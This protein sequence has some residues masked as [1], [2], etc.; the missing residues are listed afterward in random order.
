MGGRNR[1]GGGGTDGRPPPLICE[2][3]LSNFAISTFQRLPFPMEGGGG[4]GGGGGG[5]AMAAEGS[6]VNFHYRHQL[7]SFT[8]LI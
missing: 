1:E 7:I 3:L 5:R 6:T 8:P 2:E 4:G